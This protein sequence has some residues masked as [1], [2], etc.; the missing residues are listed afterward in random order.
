MKST[1]RDILLVLGATVAC[2]APFLDKPF[3][4][5]DTCYIMCA[6][7]IQENPWDFYG[8]DAN[9]YGF[10][11]PMYQMNQ[12]PPLVPYYM[13]AAASL[14]GWSEVALHA[15]F[16]LPTIALSLG[17][18]HL[19]RF[20]CDH[21]RIAALIAILSPAFLVSSTSVMLDIPMVALY[22]WAV[23]LWL[24]GIKNERLILLLCSSFLICLSMMAKYY[25][26]TAAPLLFA[27]SLAVKRRPGL[28]TLIL[29]IPAAGLAGYEILSHKLYGVGLLGNAVSYASEYQASGLLL[30]VRK[31]MVAMVYVGGCMAG[32]IFF[33][34]VLWSRR[35][36]AIAA[37]SAVVVTFILAVTSLGDLVM[38]NGYPMRWYVA[39]QFAL[40][41][42][43][44]AGIVAL[45]VQDLCHRRDASSLL[46]A[47]WI[48]GAFAFSG[49]I[50]WTTN[51]RTMLP[52]LPAAG[53]V[54]ARRLDTV[55]AL[56]STP[57]GI[58]LRLPLFLAG[59]LAL[60]VVWADVS[61]A[62][63]Q[64][65][66]SR[67]I[68]TQF[69]DDSRSVWFDGHWGFQYYMDAFGAHALD[70]AR[71]T[72]QKGDIFVI[73]SNNCLALIPPEFGQRKADQSAFVQLESKALQPSRWVTT[74]SRPLGAG[75]YAD[76]TGCMP[77]SF[78]PVPTETYVALRAVESHPPFFRH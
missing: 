28:W 60:I 22:V 16:L 67:Q 19:A 69:V 10:D 17:I 21:P 33:S 8:F 63:C 35:T 1:R 55:S 72:I 15:A 54:I 9:W 70:H 45:T 42:T 25:G 56:R 34:H 53:I 48:M 41:M 57:P 24:Q 75:Y 18:Y 51:V 6:E 50:N 47:L 20:F 74:V 44:G 2:L 40:L 27:Y 43:A 62:N 14:L 52:M 5:D 11:Q 71:S 58:T 37:L 61:N 73:P 29:L 13:A 30:F 32:A 49:F 46:L 64:R 23:I 36:I 31:P 66:A 68:C 59:I 3:H 76:K 65:S 78:G 39:M 4:I 12:N 38:M 26:F 7:H 77:F